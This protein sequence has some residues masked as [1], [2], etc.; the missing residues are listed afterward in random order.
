MRA[1][2]NKIRRV[3]RVDFERYA[4]DLEFS[5][6]HRGTV[7]LAFIFARPRGLAR[8]I[9]IGALFEKCF[10]LDGMLA[11]PN[12]YELCADALRRLSQ[13]KPARKARAA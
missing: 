7:D 9:V 6:G 13:A 4:I 10:V 1:Y 12:G 5:D 2:G 8:E 11:W 3:R